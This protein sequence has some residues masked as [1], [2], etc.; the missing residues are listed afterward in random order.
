MVEVKVVAKKPAIHKVNINRAA[1]GYSV[2][3]NLARDEYCA[4]EQVYVFET[5]AAM[6]KWLGKNM[7][8]AAI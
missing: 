7:P 4:A 3:V 2:L 8:V 1:N 6:S 5:F